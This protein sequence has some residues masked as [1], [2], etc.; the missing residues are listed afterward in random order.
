[1]DTDYQIEYFVHQL[2][3][4]SSFVKKEHQEKL[5]DNT[6]SFIGVDEYHDQ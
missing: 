2:K 1:M 6:I 4:L 3:Q 5:L